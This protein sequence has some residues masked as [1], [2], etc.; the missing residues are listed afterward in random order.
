MQYRI[1]IETAF[2]DAQIRRGL[3]LM[4]DILSVVD[5]ACDGNADRK[6][7]AK[8]VVDAL[9][10]STNAPFILTFHSFLRGAVVEAVSMRVGGDT[11]SAVGYFLNR[12][13]PLVKSM[14]NGKSPSSYLE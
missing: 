10:C 12:A 6:Q 5:D 7:I 14:E 11:Q 9:Y 3:I 8:A 1:K 13:I 2:E 4:C